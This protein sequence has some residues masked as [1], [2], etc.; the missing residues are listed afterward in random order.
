MGRDIVVRGGLDCPILVTRVG[1]DGTTIVSSDI[2]PTNGDRFFVRVVGDW[3]VAIVDSMYRGA[4]VT[5]PAAR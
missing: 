1:R 2:G 3:F 5:F 4:T